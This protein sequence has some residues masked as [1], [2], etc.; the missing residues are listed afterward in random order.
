MPDQFGQAACGIVSQWDSL[1]LCSHWSGDGC[2]IHSV[3]E[4]TDPVYSVDLIMHAHIVY[5]WPSSMIL[6]V[7]VLKQW[8]RILAEMINLQSRQYLTLLR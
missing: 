7:Q 2:H 1:S 5:S 4:D 8:R 6:S 3:S